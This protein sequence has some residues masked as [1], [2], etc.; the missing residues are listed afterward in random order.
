MTFF[1]FVGAPTEQ[2]DAYLAVGD[3]MLVTASGFENLSQLPRE[4]WVVD[5]Q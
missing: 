5:T 2:E 1:Y 4:L 3:P